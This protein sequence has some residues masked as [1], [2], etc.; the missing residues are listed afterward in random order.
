MISEVS[1]LK[2]EPENFDEKYAVAVVRQSVKATVSHI[3]YNFAPIVS[4]FLARDLNKAVAEVTGSRV[5]P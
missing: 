2:G 4:P 1:S 3:P 5:N